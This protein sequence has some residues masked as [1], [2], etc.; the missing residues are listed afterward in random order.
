[1]VSLK[2]PWEVL[3]SVNQRVNRVGDRLRL[4][5][6]YRSRLAAAEILV[7]SQ[8]R[9]YRPRF[10]RFTGPVSLHLSFFEPDKRRRDPNN[11]VK[12]IEDSMSGVVYADDSQI[13]RMSWERS[14]IDRKE[15]RVEIR[16]EALPSKTSTKE[17]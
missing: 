10:P 9:G 13:H 3:A 16:V 17:E 8:V 11:L 4:T 15:P 1:M 12:L 14:G 7:L 6:T 2:L 5:H